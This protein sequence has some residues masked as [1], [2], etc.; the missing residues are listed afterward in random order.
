MQSEIDKLIKRYQTQEKKRHLWTRILG[1]IV[2]LG[3]LYMVIIPGISSE[4]TLICSKEE[5]THIEEC[6]ENK[7]IC[8]IEETEESI[9]SEKKLNC[10]YSQD[11]QNF[12]IHT[13]DDICYDDKGNLICDLVE[14]THHSHDENCYDENQNLICTITEI[15]HQHNDDCFEVVSTTQEGHH[16]SD[17]C[18]ESVLVCD[19]EV[20][21]HTEACY[22]KEKS[23]ITL[24]SEVDHINATVEYQKGVLPEGTQLHI[25]TLSRDQEEVQAL[26]EKIYEMKSH[27]LT[28]EYVDISFVDSEGNEIEPQGHVTVTLSFNQQVKTPES[29]AQ[30]QWILI[31][32]EE[33][34]IEDLTEQ[35]TTLFDTDNYNALNSVTFEN[36]SFSLYAIAAYAANDDA[37]TYASIVRVSNS[38]ELKN[39]FSV[40]NNG[41][42]IRLTSNINYN[43]TSITL[44][45]GNYTLDLNGYKLTCNDYTLFKIQSGA[46]LNII[47]N[48]QGEEVVQTVDDSL[49]GNVAT[50]SNNTLTYYITT[51]E[52]VDSKT[53]QT[54]EQ[55]EK[56]TISMAGTIVGGSQP[57]FQ[58]T[59]GTLNVQSGMIYNGTGR[60]IVQ[61]TG[62]SN[63]SGGY[64]CGFKQESTNYSSDTYFGGAIKV[65]GGQLNL[66]G[67][68]LAGNTAQNGGA[69]Y[70]TGSTELSINDDGIISGNTA[71]CNSSDW[72]NHS[73]KSAY[74]CGGGGIYAKENVKITMNNGYITNNVA[75][76]DKGY[77]D[78]GGGVCLSDK[79]AMEMLGGYVTGN[80]AQGGGGIRTDFGKETQ[81][82]MTDGF[83]SSNVSTSAEGGG[84]AIDRNGVGTITGG[85]ITNNKIPKTAHWGGGGLFC[86]DG[87]TLNLRKVLITNNTAGGFG[88]GVAGCPTGNLYL[89]VT[90]GAAIYDNKDTVDKDSPHFTSD[91]VKQIDKE[92]CTEV[93][94]SNGHADYFCALNSTV[95]GTM[96][97]GEAANWQGSADYKPVIAEEGDLLSAERVMGLKANPTEE[98]KIAAKQVAKVYINGNYSYTHGGGIMCN[99]NL[100]I[101]VPKDIEVP[102]RIDLQATKKLVDG[103]GN[104]QS[105][106]GNDFSFKVTMTDLNGDVIANGICDSNGNIKFDHQLTFKKNGTYV[107][108][109]YEEVNEEDESVTY[110]KTIYRLIV[111]VQK[112]GGQGWYGDTTKYT[113]LVTSVKIE[114]SLDGENWKLVSQNDTSQSGII[115]L[116]LTS[117]ATFTNRKVEVTKVKVQKK[118]S[119]N[120]PGANSVTVILKK[121]GEEYRCQELNEDNQWTY[122]W[123]DLEVNHKYTVEEVL[124]P[125]Y[126]ASYNITTEQDESMIEI[127]NETSWWV[128][129]TQLI[130]GNKYL[131]VSPDGSKA[132]YISKNHENNGFDTSDVIDVTQ[133]TGNLIVNDQTYTTWFSSDSIDLRCIFTAQTRNKENH[134][135]TILKCDGT[136]NNT[137]LLVQNHNNNY[138]KSTSQDT[139]ASNMEFDNS[140]LKGHDNY[141]WNPTSLRTV[142]YEDNKFNTTTDQNPNNAV[143]LYTLVSGKGFTGS[144]TDCTTIEIT[145]TKIAENFEL[146]ET[147][148]NGYSNYIVY[149]VILMFISIMGYLIRL[150]S[151]LK[152]RQH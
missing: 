59:G 57:V 19:K 47:D 2:L 23:N 98:A 87:S 83:V 144:F 10:P 108:Y 136:T 56:H 116:P 114:S 99:G 37:T 4:Q 11:K 96:L 105:L 66:S 150:K 148:D 52:I 141:N 63:L 121:D 38:T 46:T 69:I 27:I 13:H 95:T 129:A 22:S 45:N 40:G 123:T 50:I 84:I 131:I 125:G 143:K 106:E 16:H 138:L 5:H 135:G 41:N 101:G 28:V 145:N 126:E 29:D 21:L 89:Y 34:D 18:Y 115:S 94:Q 122:I 70:A 1:I 31:H 93:F 55:L 120:I 113:Y 68:V 88:A 53:G 32:E 48:K 60:A 127:P 25:Q 26:E 117:G 91:G 39:A 104:S 42:T 119:D 76:D 79:S 124:V 151:V 109:I 86:A 90:E 137:W 64:I 51:S 65:Q 9:V 24:T 78:G 71:N 6:Y 128:P 67:T 14:H 12:I 152:R 7:L 61:T 49:A 81:F 142:I 147:G 130:P 73:E 15:E 72:N 110:D 132:L 54:Q 20:H 102:A 111:T 118:W 103:S 134:T 58:V 33:T 107:Y 92:I 97:G 62:I 139:Y 133:H 140:I 77:F 146:P 30:A 3:S 82:K 43:T 74:R 8:E 80:K 85:Y 17:E 100:V 112:D 35:E 36:D 149:G 44:P 75:T